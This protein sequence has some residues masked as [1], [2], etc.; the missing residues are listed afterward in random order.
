M[1]A[2][3][4]GYGFNNDGLLNGSIN[5]KPRCNSIDI[6]IRIHSQQTI[7]QPSNTCEHKFDLIL[8]GESSYV[9]RSFLHCHIGVSA[10]RGSRWQRDDL[11]QTAG[12]L[13]GSLGGKQQQTHSSLPRTIPVAHRHPH[14]NCQLRAQHRTLCQRVDCSNHGE[15]GHCSWPDVLRLHPWNEALHPCWHAPKL[16]T[17]QLCRQYEFHWIPCGVTSTATRPQLLRNCS[18]L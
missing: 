18:S 7:D 13:R 11:Q 2:C 6:Y 8:H 16:S 17:Q 12:L 3:L 10:H 5:F 4:R 9:D 1:I 15:P 14:R